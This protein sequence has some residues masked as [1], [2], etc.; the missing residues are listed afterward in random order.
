MPALATPDRDQRLAPR[1]VSSARDRLAAVV[2]HPGV[3]PAITS[4]ARRSARPGAPANVSAFTFSSVPSRRRRRWPRPAGSPRATRSTSSRGAPSPIGSPT[5]PR[6]TTLAVRGAMRRGLRDART[7]PRRRPSGPRA[8][9]SRL[10]GG[11]KPR[12][13]RAG[14]D[15]DDDGQRVG[16]GDAEPVHLAL[17]RR[18]CAPAPRRS[19]GR[20]RARRTSA[21]LG[22][23]AITEASARE[24]LAAARAARRRT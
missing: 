15:L 24:P 10:D 14:Q 8:A 6:S 21:A 11:D 9:A 16:V 7:I 18:R 3:A 4:R 1:R 19:R 2:E 23:A 17:R 20:R 22:D 12:V 13:H 5:R